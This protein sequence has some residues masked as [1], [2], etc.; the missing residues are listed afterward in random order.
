MARNNTVSATFNMAAGDGATG[1]TESMSAAFT[2]GDSVLVQ[3]TVG[4]AERFFAAEDYG[5]AQFDGIY[6]ENRD[7]TSHLE[8]DLFTT[9]D[10]TTT[11][12]A[13]GKH[14]EVAPGGCFLIR[15]DAAMDAI[16]CVGLLGEAADVE[17]VLC[18]AE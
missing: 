12:F 15:F 4:T 18:L 5:M 17:F 8:V 14:L 7:T 2:S 1:F 16:L 10:N 11:L 9:Q 6:V 13:T 3:G